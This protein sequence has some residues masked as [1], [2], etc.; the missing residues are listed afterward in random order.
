MSEAIKVSEDADLRAYV[1]LVKQNAGMFK[2]YFKHGFD[3][4]QEIA[5]DMASRKGWWNGFNDF[6]DDIKQEILGNKINLM[7]CELS[8][9]TEAMRIGNPDSK[10][11]PAFS[12]V[13]EELADEVIRIMDFA[14]KNDLRIAEAIVAKIIYNASRPYKHGKKF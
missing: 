12:S 3:G 1:D 9:A 7:H 4:L 6:A 14:G 10:K 8:E 13:E 2:N 5:H 11:I